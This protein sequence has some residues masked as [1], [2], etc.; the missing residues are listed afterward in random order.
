MEPT[1]HRTTLR[2]GFIGSDNLFDKYLCYWLRQHSDL[3]VIVWTDQLRWAA[4][5]RRWR[6]VAARYRR[7]A[8]RYGWVR[9]LDEIL[10][11]VIYGG[12]MRR[13]D[14]DRLRA[15]IEGLAAAE[16][17]N[18]GLDHI[19]QVPPGIRELR[20]A[21]IES[22]E[23]VEA[24]RAERLDVLFSMCLD[25]RVPE[26]LISEPRLGSYLWHEGITP[27]YRG[28]HSPFWALAN[29]DYGALG[30]TLLKM[31]MEFDGGDAYVQGTV[32]DVDPHLDP[33]SYI[34]HKAI[35]DSLDETAR[36]LGDLE[37]GEATPLERPVSEDRLYS[38]PTASALAKLIRRRRRARSGRRRGE[39][40]REAH[41]GGPPVPGGKEREARQSGQ[42][43]QRESEEPVEPRVDDQELSGGGQANGRRRQG[44]PVSAG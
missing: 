18:R 19:E 42:P 11:Y 41:V 22:P 34:G 29:G 13:R 17:G 4:G 31:N 35:V 16:G 24:I 36:F 26:A 30:Y 32:R 28:V 2:T 9:V 7:R 33:P 21:T 3:R 5:P 43:G 25:V 1:R 15:L 23:V 8:T 44:P 10:Y 27:A 39:S 14:S 6:K 20:P 40:R 12:M 37:R 38:Y